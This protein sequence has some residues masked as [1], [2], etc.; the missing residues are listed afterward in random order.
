[1]GEQ[2][3]KK[4]GMHRDWLGQERA[5]LNVVVFCGLCFFV[6]PRYN[7]FGECSALD[8]LVDIIKVLV[9]LVSTLDYVW[10]AHTE[11]V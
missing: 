1:M 6:G 11:I 4:C 10:H 9:L 8:H 7:C 2:R 5:G 3:I